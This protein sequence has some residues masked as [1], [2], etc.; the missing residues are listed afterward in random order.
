MTNEDVAH[1]LPLREPQ[2]G[3]HTDIVL[4]IEK[5]TGKCGAAGCVHV[6]FRG[7]EYVITCHHVL[8]NDRD[9][10]TGPLRLKKDM[11]EEDMKHEVPPMEFIGSDIACDVAVFRLKGIQ[12]QDI[13]K[14]AYDLS[15]SPFTFDNLS[16]NLGLLSFIYGTPGFAQ[17][18]F[19]Y[20]DLVLYMNTP[21]Y[22]AHGPIMEVL[23][24]KIVSDFAEKD[25]LELNT[26]VAPQLV[27]FQPS[28]GAR[29][30]RGMSG[31]GLWIYSGLSDKF[32]LAGI[33]R[34]RN[35]HCDLATEHLINFC[36]VWKLTEFLE[37]LIPS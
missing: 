26:N 19:Q 7:L 25:L 1:L 22:I 13:P 2:I 3:I 12:L 34:G 24:E 6:L 31:S 8:K 32:E 16:K 9:Y 27:G 17:R 33:L 35:D 10:F 15:Q 11:I 30:L 20:P 37:S 5:G 14:S 18:Y 4:S 28:G 29:D 23:P 36:P 21:V